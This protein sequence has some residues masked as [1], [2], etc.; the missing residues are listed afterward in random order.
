MVNGIPGNMAVKVAEYV[1]RDP[2]LSLIP[3]ALTGPEILESEFQVY[4]TP[5]R[6]ITPEERD[7]IVR[8]VKETEGDFICVDYTT[9]DAVNTNA[10]FYSSQNLSFVMGTTGGDR[11]LLKNTVEGSNV[12]AVVA[13]NMAK[14]IVAFQAMMEYASKNFPGVFK[15]YKLEIKE[16]HQKGKLD[17]SGTAKAMV[18]YFNLLGI[19]F[20]HDEIIM[21]RDPEVQRSEW[22]VPEEF[23]KGHGWHTYTLT[24]ADGTVQFQ[25]KHNVNGRDVYAMGTLD[26]I[27]YLNKKLAQGNKGKVFSMIDVLKGA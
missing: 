24:S 12:C 25:F 13:P 23:L 19:P 4:S 16:S 7:E 27:Y 6:L 22:G 20:T 1:C 9:P 17:T 3:F 14:Q 21:E 2:G 8:T 5:I 18:K 10:S 11:E 26:A 15:G